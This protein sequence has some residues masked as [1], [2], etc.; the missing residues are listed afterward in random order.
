LGRPMALAPDVATGQRADTAGR[1]G[2]FRICRSKD[3]S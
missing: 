1:D 3:G 2:T